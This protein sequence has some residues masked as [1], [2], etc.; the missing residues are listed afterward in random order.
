MSAGWDLAKRRIP[1]P[2]ILFGLLLGLAF[3]GVTG[4]LNGLG[5]A[6]L[7]AVV[8]F[9]LTFP[10]W[11]MR[12]MG[13]G[14]AKLMMVVGTFLGPIGVVSALVY[15]TCVHGLVALGML[16]LRGIG[17][18]IGRDLLQDP[19]APMAVAITIGASLAIR[20]PLIG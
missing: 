10:Q 6:F 15:A 11:A 12:W 3:G 14:D 4:G 1:N 20:F 18:R 19:R 9:A 5:F 17:Q 8:A 16:L 13:G 2:L 7:G